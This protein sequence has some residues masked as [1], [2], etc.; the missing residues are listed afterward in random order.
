MCTLFPGYCPSDDD[1]ESADSWTKRD[2]SA[3][4]TH[5]RSATS[6]IAKRGASKKYLITLGEI[7]VTAVAPAHPS[8]GSLYTGTNTDQVIRTG[9]KLAQTYCTTAGLSTFNVPSGTQPY[10]LSGKF[11]METEHPLDV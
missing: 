9:F 5:K 4:Y 8:I 10:G 3:V 7:I 6:S 2:V 11:G 1:D